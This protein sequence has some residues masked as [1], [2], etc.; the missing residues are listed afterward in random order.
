MKRDNSSLLWGAA[1]LFFLLPLAVYGQQQKTWSVFV[2]AGAGVNGYVPMAQ[3][4]R[5]FL[6]N[7]EIVARPWIDKTP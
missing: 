2:N 5:E 4:E 3:F 1:L 7:P 6:T